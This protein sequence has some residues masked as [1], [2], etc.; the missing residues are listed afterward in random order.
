MAIEITLY[1]MNEDP[2]KVSK[3]LPSATGKFLNFSTSWLKDQ[4]SDMTPNVTLAT[5]DDL[6]LYN[7]MKVGSPVNRYYFIKPTIVSTGLW[8]LN[9][10]EDVLQ[11]FATE[12]KSNTGIVARSENRFNTYLSDSI[13]EG[14]VYRRTCT[15]PF[16]ATPFSTDSGGYYL[17]TTGGTGGA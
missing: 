15:I 9:A 1:K 3:T 6:L 4:F 10:H 12:I 14:L 5:S 13:F 2:R 17:T 8:S 11:N 16:P 7:Y